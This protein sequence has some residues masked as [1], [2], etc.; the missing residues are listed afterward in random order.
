[1][2]VR[3]RV[4]LRIVIMGDM[5]EMGLKSFE[6]AIVLLVVLKSAFVLFALGFPALVRDWEFYLDI[7]HSP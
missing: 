7:I 4:R 5:T 6:L 3:I 1:M 2:M